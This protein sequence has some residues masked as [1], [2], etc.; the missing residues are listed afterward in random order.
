MHREAHASVTDNRQKKIAN[1][2]QILQECLIIAY[3]NNGIFGSQ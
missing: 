1:T 3:R 2:C